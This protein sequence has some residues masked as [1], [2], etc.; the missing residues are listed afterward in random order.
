MIRCLVY[1]INTRFFLSLYRTAPNLLQAFRKHPAGQQLAAGKRRR[2]FSRL[3]FGTLEI[4]IIM[5]VLL[6]V[7]LI[8]RQTLTRYAS[9]LIETVFKDSIIDDIGQ[10]N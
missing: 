1:L 6:S 9:S 8:F 7:A 5:A 4:V 3:G 2:S 10:G